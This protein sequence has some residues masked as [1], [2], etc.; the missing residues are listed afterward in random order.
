MKRYYFDLIDSNG[1][2]V[3][4][5]GMDLADIEAAQ[6]E[7]ARSLADFARGALRSS[8][9]APADMA[10]EVRTDAGA[11]MRVKFSFEIERTN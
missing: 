10:V 9:A 3:D 1:I 4:D 8:P 11:V 6:D 7:A 5:E 2:V